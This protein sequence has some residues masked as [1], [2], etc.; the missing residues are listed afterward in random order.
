MNDTPVEMFVSSSGT[1]ALIIPS[2]NADT[3]PIGRIFS[4]PLRYKTRREQRILRA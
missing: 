1:A 4:T 2:S 3:L